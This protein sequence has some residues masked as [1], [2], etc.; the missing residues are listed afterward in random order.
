MKFGHGLSR[1]T[2]LQIGLA[3][4]ALPETTPNRL[5]RVLVQVLGLPLT[6]QKLASL[7]VKTLKTAMKG[8]FS[9]VDPVYL[10]QALKYLKGEEAL[11]PEIDTPP[12]QPYRE[13]DMPGSIRVAFASNGG[14]RL[15][16]HFGSCR[17]FLI[18]QVS[19][20]EARLIEVRAVEEPD[21]PVKDEK[22]LYRTNL[23][24]DCHLLYI[25]SI[26]GPPAARIVNAGVHPIK[27]PQE[28][29]IRQILPKLQKRL[30]IT[31][32]P[33]LAKAM[34]IERV[35]PLYGETEP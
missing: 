30:A 9:E 10:K 21:T 25:I 13:G 31:P 3:A 26:G 20:T 2:A 14:E 33:W 22:N 29:E 19:A 11:I 1:A 8:E 17:R 6:E 34:G 15:D 24:S 35:L 18:Y 5:L 32:P 7:T 23:V 12:L 27:H 4:R 28:V 16:G